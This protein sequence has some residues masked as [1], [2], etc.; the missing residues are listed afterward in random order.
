MKMPFSHRPTKR[1]SEFHVRKSGNV[2][3]R[4]VSAKHSHTAHVLKRNVAGDHFCVAEDALPRNGTCFPDRSLPGYLVA[5]PKFVLIGR[6]CNSGLRRPPRS[7]S[8]KMRKPPRRDE[9]GLRLLARVVTQKCEKTN[10]QLSFCLAIEAST[11]FRLLT[12]LQSIPIVAALQSVG[13]CSR[14]FSKT[15]DER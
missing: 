7:G 3:Y 13:E 8:S 1:P 5:T 9:R 15:S 12:R 11:I 10:R 6:K 2:K 4:L 14:A